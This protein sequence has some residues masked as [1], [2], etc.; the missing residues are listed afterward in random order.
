M[1]AGFSLKKN[2]SRTGGHRPP[3]QPEHVGRGIAAT[4]TEIVRLVQDLYGLTAE[5]IEL[6]EGQA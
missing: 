5:E 6:V 2:K 1:R 3:L 4:H